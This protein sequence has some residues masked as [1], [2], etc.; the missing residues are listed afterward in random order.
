MK[1]DS[2][3]IRYSYLKSYL[4]L[5]EYISNNKYIYRAKEISKYLF[6]SY[7]F[8]SLIWTTLKNKLFINY[9]LFLLFFNISFGIEVNINYLNKINIYTRKYY[10]VYKLEDN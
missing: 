9:L 4:Y 7:S 10:L 1:I 8:F 2:K 5:L 3:K 6:L